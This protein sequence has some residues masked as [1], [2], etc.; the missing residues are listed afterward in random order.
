M[1]HKDL[2]VQA[3]ECKLYISRKECCNTSVLFPLTTDT[4]IRRIQFW[5]L[6]ILRHMHTVLTHVYTEL[7]CEWIIIMMYRWQ[8]DQ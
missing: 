5:H 1:E 6:P 4:N 8:Q 7:I 2:S 3:E